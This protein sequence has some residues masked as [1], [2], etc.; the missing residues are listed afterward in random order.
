MSGVEIESVRLV[1]L[2]DQLGLTASEQYPEIAADLLVAGF[3]SPAL[4]ELA[5]YPRSD[6]RGARDLWIQTRQELNRP[7]E[8][9]ETARRILV[10]AWLGEIVAGT[11]EPRTGV[12]LIYGQGWLELRQPTE[13]DYFVGL[14][15]DWDDMPQQREHICDLII[16]AARETLACWRT[17]EHCP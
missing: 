10:R 6:P 15:D 2:R 16:A 14:L 1:F 11:L 17:T 13:L 9:D 4:R 3:D 8:D 5:G 12:G 7:F